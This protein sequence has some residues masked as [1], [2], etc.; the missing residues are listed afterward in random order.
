MLQQ[1]K[2]WHTDST[3]AH[4]HDH[5]P[6]SLIEGVKED[7]LVVD[8]L[9][10]DD[11]AAIGKGATT[12]REVGEAIDVGLVVGIAIRRFDGLDTTLLVCLL[13]AHRKT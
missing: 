4:D 12:M 7:D 5:I 9:K 8:K 6:L 2:I 13:N 3:S 10:L 11:K 1:A